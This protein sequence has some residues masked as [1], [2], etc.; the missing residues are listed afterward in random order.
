MSGDSKDSDLGGEDLLSELLDLEGDG[1]QTEVLSSPDELEKQSF[2]KKTDPSL[3]SKEGALPPKVDLPFEDENDKTEFIAKT[4]SPQKEKPAT[5]NL[6]SFLFEDDEKTEFSQDVERQALEIEASEKDLEDFTLTGKTSTKSSDDL[7]DLENAISEITGIEHKSDTPPEH[8]EMTAPPGD[9]PFAEEAVEKTINLDASDVLLEDSPFDD[10]PDEVTSL[11]VEDVPEALDN[12]PPVS[13]QAHEVLEELTD[14]SIESEVGEVDPIDAALREFSDDNR[15]SQMESAHLDP[16]ESPSDDQ[17]FQD[18]SLENLDSLSK[19]LGAEKVDEEA[20]PAKAESSSEQVQVSAED[21]ADVF[22][23]GPIEIP[24]EPA[25]RTAI[26]TK[27]RRSHLLYGSIAAAFLMAFASLIYVLKSD[28]GLL[29]Y[30]V[31]GFALVPS[32]RAPSAEDLKDFAKIM[33]SASEARRS[34]SPQKMESVVTALESILIRDERN[35]EGASELLEV[36]GRL[37]AWRGVDGKTV[38]KF[39]ETLKKIDE[40]RPQLDKE[41][42]TEQLERAKAWRSLALN[43]FLKSRDQLLAVEKA[44]EGKLES[45]TYELLFELNFRAGAT[46]RAS[47]LI[48][49]IEKPSSTRFRFFEALLKS[50]KNAIQAL[51]VENYL[52]AEVESQLNR[53]I[54]SKEVGRDL[55][56]Q[57]NRIYQEVQAYPWLLQKVKSL[58]GDI[59]EAIGEFEKAKNEWAEVVQAFPEASAVWE[60]LAV[61]YEK[62]KLWDEATNAYESALKT[63]GLRVDLVVRY[64]RLQRQRNKIVES[65]EILEKSLAAFPRSVP[66]HYEQGLTQMTIF[67]DENAQKSFQSALEINPQFEPATVALANLAVRREELEEADKLFA[68]VPESSASYSSALLGRAHLA[69]RQFRMAEA[70]RLYGQAIRIDEKNEDAYV[71]MTRLLIRKGKLQEAEALSRSGIDK[72]PDSP[73]LAASLAS[74]FVERRK[75]DQAEEIIKPFLKSHSHAVSPWLLQAEIHMEKSNFSSAREILEKLSESEINNAD[76]NYYK[77]KLYFLDN[78]ELSPLYGGRESAQS[79]V[80]TA[81][82]IDPNNERFMLLAAEIERKT[83]DRANAREYVSD[84][85]RLYPDSWKAHQALGEL[86]YEEGNIEAALK[87]YAM[88][89]KLG[90]F[91]GQIYSKMAQAYRSKGDPKNALFYFRKTLKWYPNDAQVHLEVGKLLNEEG[92]YLNALQQLRKAVNLNPGLAEAY[93]YLGFIQKE[94]GDNKSAIRSFKRYLS[95]E[96]NG[97]ESA[98]VK[99][100]VYFLEQLGAAN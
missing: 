82:S 5:D 54:G 47:E 2:T 86:E 26:F 53:Q 40:I 3:L 32:Y 63:G 31:E 89:E 75:F 35:F 88:A 97:V 15:R 96:P 84:V 67:Q 93:Y 45:D 95:K 90:P 99:D 87:A 58:R 56:S 43:E 20:A 70:S 55:L 34:D 10:Q 39:D 78:S 91:K 80:R 61:A 18:S 76:L 68:Q 79:F 44:Q 62:D 69:E 60:K 8:S 28:E 66:L 4:E 98:T 42:R 37:L 85:L 73:L 24:E 48:A 25:R 27:I 12:S 77:A 51:A 71:G 38:T 9:N 17:T 21:F 6:E 23:S 81:M 11:D 13:E 92:A 33:K 74:V 52:P 30:R 22:Q 16:I 64:S 1:D 83:D 65:L 72:L 46:D 36:L 14:D 94:L 7:S 29:G 100:E 57:A 49:K 41:V 59:F 50:D 19:D